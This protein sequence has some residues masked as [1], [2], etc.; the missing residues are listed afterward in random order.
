MAAKGAVIGRHHQ[1]PSAHPPRH[2]SSQP[3]PSRQPGGPAKRHSKKKSRTSWKAGFNS[4]PSSPAQNG[5]E[6]RLSVLTDISNLRSTFTSDLSTSSKQIPERGPQKDFPTQTNPLQDDRPQSVGNA[7]K[8]QQWTTS[9]RLPPK[10]KNST[11]KSEFL[12]TLDSQLTKIQQEDDRV[13]KPQPSDHN[14]AKLLS[15]TGSLGKSGGSIKILEQ[16]L[17]E[18]LK[19]PTPTG[20]SSEGQG[21][22][23]LQQRN[24]LLF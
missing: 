20:P 17:S 4:T 22:K 23:C 10:E 5:L 19:A 1:P 21:S 14:E 13:K 24:L 18:L 9:E 15:R 8:P 12:Q 2:M 3:S 16:E 6:G 11:H 7:E